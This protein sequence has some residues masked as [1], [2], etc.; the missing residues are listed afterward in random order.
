M[1][2]NLVSIYQKAAQSDRAEMLASLVDILLAGRSARPA[3]RES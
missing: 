2:R 1:M 3:A